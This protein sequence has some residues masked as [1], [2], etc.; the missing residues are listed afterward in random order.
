M[1]ELN[2]ILTIPYNIIIATGLDIAATLFISLPKSMPDMRHTG[3]VRY[4]VGSCSLNCT[5]TVAYG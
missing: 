4:S 3:Q 2:L 1:K 5:D